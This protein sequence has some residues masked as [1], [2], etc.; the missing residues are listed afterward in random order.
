MHKQKQTGERYAPADDLQ[1]SRTRRPAVKK[2]DRDATSMQ[3][4]CCEYEADS[5]RKWIGGGGQFR[6]MRV[7]M[8]NREKADEK[9]SG[10]EGRPGFPENH[11]TEQKCRCGDSDFDTW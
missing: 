1:C 7:A 10:I 2:A 9:R 6:S 8:K 5:V 11:E 3:E 4:T